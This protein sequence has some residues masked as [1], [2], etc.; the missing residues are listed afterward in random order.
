MPSTHTNLHY[1]FVFA[2]KDHIPLIRKEWRPRLHAYIG[3]IIKNL[4]GVPLAVGGMEDHAHIL[5][6]LRSSHRVDYVLRDI[7]AD[8]SLFIRKECEPKFQWQKGYGAFTVSPSGIEAVRQYIL[9][10]ESHHRKHKFKD[11]YLAFLRK[12]NTPFDENFL[13]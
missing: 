10:Q 1:H 11:E 2:T 12:T 8:S 6:G 9:D 4:G 3:G 5:T 7:K 13:W